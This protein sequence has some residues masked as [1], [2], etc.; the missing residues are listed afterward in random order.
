M[1]YRSLEEFGRFIDG[2]LALDFD[3]LE[4][5]EE[6]D[7][8][9]REAV[10]DD[11]VRAFLLQDLRRDGSGWRWQPNLVVLSEGLEA[12]RDWPGAAIS[13]LPPYDGPT[14]W[15]GGAESGYVRPVHAEAMSALFP[16]V[17]RVTVKGAGH[18]VHSE[19]PAIFTEVL[20]RFL[21]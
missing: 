18:W 10:P 16:R 11:T 2:M 3:T 15:I 13:S 8:R 6:A 14:L 1:S 5:R 9:L 12:L 20:R 17:R 7:E 4:R 19:Q 21:D